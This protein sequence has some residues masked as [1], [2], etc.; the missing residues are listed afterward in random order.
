MIIKM[1]VAAI[2]IVGGFGILAI[3][4]MIVLQKTRDIAILR[5]VG[6]RRADILWLFL[7]QGVIIA[8]LGAALGNLGGWRM[9]EFL[10]GL[11]I[12]QE[13]L[14]RSQTFL[15]H[16]D[17]AYYLYGTI[18]AIVT[19]VTASLLPAWRGSRVEP[20]DVLRGNT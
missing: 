9:V 4:I 16:K 8:A 1:V 7:I 18:F 15:V 17:A 14:V 11:R 6:L 2:L 19:G 20:V 10:G 13:G 12:R 5:S 3:Q